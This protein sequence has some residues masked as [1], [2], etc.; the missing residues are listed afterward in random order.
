MNRVLVVD[1]DC[2]MRCALA[3]MF[4]DRGWQA[5]AAASPEEALQACQKGAPELVVS[6]VRMPHGGGLRLVREL[7]TLAPQAV[8]VMMTAFGGIEEAVE[9]MQEGASDYLIKPVSVEL[10]ER[11]V[12]RVLRRE[13]SF[14]ERGRAPQPLREMERELFESTLRATRGN[15]SRAAKLLGVSLRTVRNKI[16]E[17]QLPARGEY[18]HGTALAGSAAGAAAGTVA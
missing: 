9:A 18:E 11:A 12:E 16:R 13:G 14:P 4:E 5:Q 2:G 6:D 7:K 3:A 8:V 17:Y 15:R 1:D 10:I